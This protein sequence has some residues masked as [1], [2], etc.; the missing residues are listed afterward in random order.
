MPSS[1]LNRQLP[2]TNCARLSR[3]FFSRRRAA[4]E[5]LDRLKPVQLEFRVS[6]SLGGE[7]AGAISDIPY[8]VT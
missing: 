2:Q 6:E 1:D 7:E 5:L 3:F 8:H 4:L